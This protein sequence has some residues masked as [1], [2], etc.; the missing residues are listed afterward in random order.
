[1][2]FYGYTEDTRLRYEAYPALLWGV[3]TYQYRRQLGRYVEPFVQIGIGAT[4]FGLL[5]RSTLGVVYR[6]A[7]SLGVMIGLEGALMRYV[8]QSVPYWTPNI[9]ITYG[10]VFRF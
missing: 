5:G 7:P 2:Q 9:G 4:E 8:H 10:V 1:M 3:A 6:P